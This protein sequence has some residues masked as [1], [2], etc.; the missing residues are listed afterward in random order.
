MGLR[1]KILVVDETRS[2]INHTVFRGTAAALPACARATKCTKLATHMRT[3]SPSF[4]YTAC[5]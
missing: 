4:Q 3:N 1:V 2:Q 5:W